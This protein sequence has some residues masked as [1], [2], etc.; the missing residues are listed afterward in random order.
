L[1]TSE[2]LLLRMR[3]Y[4]IFGPTC[5]S[6]LASF[7]RASPHGR[8]ELSLAK[9]VLAMGG[10]L[11]FAYVGRATAGA[12]H[13]SPL[14]PLFGPTCSSCL[15][16][17][18]R[19]SPHG[20]LELS[21]PKVMLA[22]GGRLKFVYVETAGVSHLRPLQPFLG[23]NCSSDIASFQRA[24][25]H[26]WLELSLAEVV[27]GMDGRLKFAYGEAFRELRAIAGRD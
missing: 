11:K 20:R 21:L 27:L 12:S 24:S 6:R 25:P 15:A 14:Q 16:S 8:L 2:K 17:L 10:R 26:G 5:R 3:I 7:Q 1:R 19:S 13:L 18:Q 22:M 9:V 23:P 4:C